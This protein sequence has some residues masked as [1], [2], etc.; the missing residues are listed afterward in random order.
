[1]AQSILL[2]E[3]NPFERELVEALLATEARIQVRSVGLGQQA[4]DLLL[5]VEATAFTQNL[6]VVLLDLSLPDVAGIDVLRAMR[7]AAAVRRIP[8]VVFSRSQRDIDVWA[9]YRLGANA[10]MVKPDSA[11]ALAAM[12]GRTVRFWTQRNVRVPH[13]SALAPN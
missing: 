11:D 9:S 5:G 4:L 1:M 8:V 7:Q 3:D 2:V 12:I 13:D 10:Y 6:S